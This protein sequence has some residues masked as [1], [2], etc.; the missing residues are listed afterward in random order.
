MPMAAAGEL[1]AEQLVAAVNT[2]PLHDQL[3]EVLLWFAPMDSRRIADSYT[4]SSLV[5]IEVVHELAD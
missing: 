1:G 3:V 5:F 4:S 2:E